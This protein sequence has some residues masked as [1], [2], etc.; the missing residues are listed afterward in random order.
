MIEIT[1]LTEADEGTLSSVN[2]LL[3][4]LSGSAPLI[5]LDRLQTLACIRMH[6]SLFG[7]GG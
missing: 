3:P 5:T 6:P 2:H 7:Q 1:E 4:Q